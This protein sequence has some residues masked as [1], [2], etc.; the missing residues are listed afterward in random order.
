MVFFFF[1]KSAMT[2]NYEIIEFVEIEKYGLNA[3][4][5]IL[6]INL[7]TDIE[8][9]FANCCSAINFELKNFFDSMIWQT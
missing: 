4:T 6:T 9:N 2:K 7:R 1:Q 8:A 5:N 3:S